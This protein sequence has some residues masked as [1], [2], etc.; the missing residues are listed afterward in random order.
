MFKQFSIT[1]IFSLLIS[2]LSIGQTK[3]IPSPP[4]PKKLVS[5]L[6]KEYPNFL[7]STES[8]LLEEK[9]V[10]FSDSTSN[11]IAIVIIDDLAG[12]EPWEFA[13]RLGEEWEVGQKDKDNG[14]VIL[15]KPTGSKAERKTFIAIGKGLE[16]AIPDATAKLILDREL[17]SNF[18]KEAYFEGLD[19]TTDVLMSLAK[20]EYNSKEYSKKKKSNKGLIKAI[21]ILVFI[22]IF[23]IIRFKNGGNGGGDGLT[24]GAGAMYFGSRG[25][26]GGFGGGSSGGGFGGFGGGGFGGGGAGGSW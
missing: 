18:K 12:F 23:F 11:Q 1:F 8:S 10:R 26:G 21:M 9:L 2:I 24:M 5:N 4:N 13:T 14:I 19:R 22:F 7:S 6:S 15:I 25:F 16:G 17:I 20:G 3:G